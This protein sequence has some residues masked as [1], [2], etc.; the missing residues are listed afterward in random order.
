MI[1]MLCIASAAAA[2]LAGPVRAADDPRALLQA[3][4]DRIA[5]A[6]GLVTGAHGVLLTDDDA[7]R[8]GPSGDGRVRVSR[9]LVAAMPDAASLD[10]MLALSLSHAVG[11]S[12]AKSPN[13]VARDVIGAAGFLGAGALGQDPTPAETRQLWT[14]DDVDLSWMEVEKRSHDAAQR[15]ALIAARSVAWAEKAGSCRA[16]LVETLR[17]LATG[18]SA[19]G[20]A[21]FDA[22]TPARR[23]LADLGTTAVD[24]AG[25][26]AARGDPAFA[27]LRASLQQP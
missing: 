1:R 16:A 4:L 23:T 2:M 12:P 27:A 17:G 5:N 3:R 9:R 24:T 14:A 13:P 10:A 19:H 18:A 8:L 26:C 21:R 20:P 25:G 11:R 7:L 6:A 22:A 15:A